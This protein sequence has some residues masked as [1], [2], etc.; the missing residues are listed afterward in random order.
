MTYSFEHTVLP[1]AEQELFSPKQEVAKLLSQ[2]NYDTLFGETEK[3]AE[4]AVDVYEL[5]QKIKSDS[6]SPLVAEECVTALYRGV[7]EKAGDILREIVDNKAVTNEL[8]KA[9][10]GLPLP[11]PELEP[12]IRKFYV[13]AFEAHDRLNNAKSDKER[14][15]L[16][17]ETKAKTKLATALGHGIPEIKDGRRREASGGAVHARVLLESNKLAK[18]SGVSPQA[19]KSFVQMMH[20]ENLPVQISAKEKVGRVIATVATTGAL[21]SVLPVG[22]AHAGTAVEQKDT[23][24]SPDII[25]DLNKPV[26]VIKP[27]AAPGPEKTPAPTESAPAA[28]A[29]TEMAPDNVVPIPDTAA[30]AP[31]TEV[32]EPKF[33]QDNTSTQNDKKTDT[34]E[35]A[36]FELTLPKN[37]TNKAKSDAKSENVAAPATKDQT[38]ET[39]SETLKE[40]PPAT[41]GEEEIN[42]QTDTPKTAESPTDEKLHDQQPAETETKPESESFEIALPKANANSD[43][44]HDTPVSDKNDKKDEDTTTKIIDH[45]DEDAFEFVLPPAEKEN[46]DDKDKKDDSE[47]EDSKPGEPKVETIG[48]K[49]S[50]TEK[51]DLNTKIVGAIMGNG[52]I[53]MSLEDAK[54]KTKEREKTKKHDG[55]DEG[56]GKYTPQ[57][58]FAPSAELPPPPKPEVPKADTYNGAPIPEVI[59]DPGLAGETAWT[60]EQLTIIRDNLDSY[61]AVAK[62]TGMPW[63]LG[64]ALHA[65]ETSLGFV[66]P[67]NG[68]GLFQL[69]SSGAHFA[70]G[71]VSKENFETQLALGM[72]FIKKKGYELGYTD[73]QMTLANPDIIKD[74]LFSY[75]GRSDKYIQQA[76]DLGFTRGAEGSPYVMNL[77]DEKRNNKTNPNWKQIL[78]DNGP[79]GN[80]NQAPGAWL[81]IEGL[82]HVEKKA[83]EQAVAKQEV[84]RKA[85]EERAAEEEKQK[86]QRTITEVEP[87]TAWHNPVPAGVPL[88]SAYGIRGYDAAGN[89]IMHTGIDYGAGM[90]TPFY[91]AAG[92][93][94]SVTV[95]GDVRSQAWCQAAIGGLEG[96]SMAEVTDPYQKEV[97]VTTKIG[98][99]TFVTIYAH[100]SEVSV[101]P[102]QIVKAGEALGKTGNSGCST[103]PHAHFG[104]EKNGK[105]IDPNIILG[106]A[107]NVSSSEINVIDDGHSHDDHEHGSGATAASID[108]SGAKSATKSGEIIASNQPADEGLLKIDH[109]S[110][111]AK[112]PDVATTSQNSSVEQAVNQAIE[113]AR[114]AAEISSAALERARSSDK[115][116]VK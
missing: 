1:S 10:R 15:D 30:V 86:N 40:T 100:M 41:S 29:K 85:A 47:K 84:E 103:G 16:L 48:Q 5:A 18:E 96:H 99:D 111:T 80:A 93:V 7:A 92:G 44:K 72:N 39:K 12:E 34:T 64:V 4:L 61:L 113:K 3:R 70:P 98:N 106:G 90:G 77:A 110:D 112:T 75:N 57:F 9:V 58:E 89:P 42:K 105:A 87:F 14:K 108:V 38:T 27:A 22:A 65:R 60:P 43:D 56:K 28:P 71:P 33:P 17:L 104:V 54:E 95:S 114:R 102:G 55:E 74:I 50:P 25:T 51:I 31:R 20:K 19:A 52:P 109:S 91:A 2:C 53:E 45:L 49:D 107:I 82:V 6:A 37:E 8:I 36:P 73:A 81:L 67:V 101:A 88:T 94:V 13:S 97:R 116:L 24:K 35:S 46:K 11:A 59:V 23:K 66:N 21:M 78:T 32:A 69:Y 79:M 68:Q 76:R 62:R 63:E 26:T 115:V 83:H